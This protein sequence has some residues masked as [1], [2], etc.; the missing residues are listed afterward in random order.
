MKARLT[1]ISREEALRYMGVRGKPDEAMEADVERC[2]EKLRAAVRPRAI[3]R[4]FALETDGTLAGTAFHP[5]GEDIRKLTAGCSHAILFAATLGTETETLIR[6]AQGVDMADAV[7]LDALASAAIENVCEN[8]C[9]DLKKEL[10]PCRLTS[11]FSPGYGDFPLVQQ[12][13]MCNVLNTSRTLGITLTQ[14]GLMIP[15]KSVTALIG[16]GEK[17]TET[18]SGCGKCMQAEYC[19]YRKEGMSCGK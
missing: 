12:R 6:R 18:V 16:V 14:G 15:Q 2:E 10:A 7:I 17:M 3:W 5:E 11:R 4:L 19:L 9:A 1:E 13:D 8:L